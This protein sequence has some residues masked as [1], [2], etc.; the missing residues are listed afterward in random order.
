MASQCATK[1]CLP[2]STLV[3][4]RSMPA[5]AASTSASSS[6][7]CASCQGHARV[8]PG[9]C[10]GHAVGRA[11]MAAG[12]HQGRPWACQRGGPPRGAAQFGAALDII[13]SGVM[14]Y[15]ERAS[16]K[17]RTCRLRRPQAALAPGGSAPVIWP[18]GHSADL[19]R[20]TA[21][22]GRGATRRSWGRRG[23]A[24]WCAPARS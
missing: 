14:T 23:G 13:E 8:T 21:S 9:S 20:L 3:T 1:R 15:S 7:V 16:V 10:Q 2:S 17:G 6:A 18:A 5:A 19:R 12:L 4:W 22:C 11:R 24:A